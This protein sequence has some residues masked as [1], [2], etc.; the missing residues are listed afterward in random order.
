[1]L[2]HCNYDFCIWLAGLKKQ[3]K[4][5]V[6]IAAASADIRSEYLLITSLVLHRY[7]SLLGFSYNAIIRCYAL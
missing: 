7:T 1:M 6:R 5:W 2:A 3:Q 4:T